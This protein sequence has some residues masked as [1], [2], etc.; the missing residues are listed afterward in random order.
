EQPNGY[1]E[2]ILHRRR[3]EFKARHSGL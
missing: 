2:P 3:R 1:T